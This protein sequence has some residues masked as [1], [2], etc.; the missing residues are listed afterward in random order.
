MSYGPAQGA[1]TGAGVLTVSG[2]DGTGTTTDNY[3]QLFSVTNAGGLDGV[4]TFYNDGAQSAKIKEAG[5]DPRF[6]KCH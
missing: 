3:V 5:T 2:K 4:G 6:T 1:P